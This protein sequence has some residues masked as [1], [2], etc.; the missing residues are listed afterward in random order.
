VSDRKTTNEVVETL[1]RQA[2]ALWRMAASSL[3][4]LREVAVRSTQAGYLR[5]DVAL[6]HRERREELAALGAEVAALIKDGELQVP[7]HVR[8]IYD[9]IRELDVRIGSASTKIHDNAFG[10]PR[11]YEPEAGNYEDDGDAVPVGGH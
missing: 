11:G 7:G 6:L 5:M 3:G 10:A 4:T 9:R 1:G 8:R 2:G